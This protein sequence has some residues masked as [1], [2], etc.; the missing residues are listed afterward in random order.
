[1]YYNSMKTYNVEEIAKITGTNDET[2]RRWIR[3]GKLPNSSALT[4]GESKVVSELDLMKFLRQTPKY[5]NRV[6]DN[7]SKYVN[8]NKETVLIG[9]ALGMIGGGILALLLD[10]D[11]EKDELQ[12]EASKMAISTEIKLSQ[13]EIEK[14]KEEIKRL[15]EEISKEQEYLNILEKRRTNLNAEE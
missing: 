6:M 9:V 10:D 8:K 15:N 7:F 1:M 13:G 14:K 12:I 2:V 5:M 3:S 4:K 11:E